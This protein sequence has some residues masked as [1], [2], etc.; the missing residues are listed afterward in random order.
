MRK[1]L[2]RAAIAGSLLLGGCATSPYGGGYG[3]DPIGN[4]LGTILGGSQGYNNR[5]LSDFERAA[6]NACGQ[7]A[8]RYGRV[9]ISDVR[10]QSASIVEVF[11]VIQSSDRYQQRQFG[12][13]FRSDGRIA[14]FRV[15]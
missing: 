14:D 3:G 6:V 2:F 5:E 11:G 1:V 7:E 4:I 12:C 9:S 10:Q 13:A 15:N 8:S